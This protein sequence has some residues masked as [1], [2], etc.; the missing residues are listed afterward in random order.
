MQTLSTVV[1]IT[2]TWMIS[3]VVNAIRGPAA[4]ASTVLYPSPAS[5]SSGYNLVPQ[6]CIWL[7]GAGRFFRDA[8]HNHGHH[9]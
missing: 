3:D 8:E 4:A 6:I 2:F 5:S 7:L 1:G 9:L